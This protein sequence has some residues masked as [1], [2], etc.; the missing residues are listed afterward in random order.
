MQTLEAREVPAVGGG[1]TVGGSVGRVLRQPKPGR[2]A[3]VH[4]AATCASTSTGGQRAPGGS[5]SPDY[6][7]VGA[8]NFSV[9]W[10]GQ[11]VPRFSETYTF[12]TTSDDGIR[13][14]VK[15]ANTGDWV[16]LVNNWDPHAIEE[17]VRSATR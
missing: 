4:A 2:H 16:E 7:R 12:R 9:R 11:L 13:L 8:D 17:N 6:R 10:T 5:T 3:G 1:F 15:P 14:W